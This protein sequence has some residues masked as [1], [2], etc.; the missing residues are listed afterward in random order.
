MNS[1]MK[2]QPS[3]ATKPNTT[4]PVYDDAFFD[5]LDE[6]SLR[7]ARVIVPMVME[8]LAPTSVV[9][10][11]CGRGG[12]LKVF[13][14]NRVTDIQGIDGDYVDRSR[15]LIDA[16]RFKTAD[17]AKPLKLSRAFDLAVCLEVAEHL[18]DCRAATLVDN[19]TAAAPL[20]LF[21]AA[22]PGQGGTAH[23]NEQWPHYWADLFATRGFQRFDLIRGRVWADRRV[24]TWYRQNIVVF[25]SARAVSQVAAL[26]SINLDDTAWDLEL[27]RKDILARYDSVRS[28][29][30]ELRR[31]LSAAIKRRW[32]RLL[33]ARTTK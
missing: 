3:M 17:L 6:G 27:V 5:W 26:S 21:S 24:E 11:G 4:A 29:W 12:W 28:L 31:L 7:S 9:D 23:V 25:A 20:I 2:D 1:T 8:L 15:L 14:E 10:I 30:K 22:I 32:K 13:L 18:P 33:G 16:D 19:L